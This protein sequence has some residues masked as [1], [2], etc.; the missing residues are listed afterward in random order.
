MTDTITL[1]DVGDG[2]LDITFSFKDVAREECAKAETK[3]FH[4]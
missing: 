1:F 3:G 4:T 2:I